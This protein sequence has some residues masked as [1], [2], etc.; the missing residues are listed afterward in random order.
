MVFQRFFG[1]FPPLTFPATQPAHAPIEHIREGLRELLHDCD[2]MA[3]E[4]AIYKI[5]VARTAADL[6]LLRS[7]L[8][9]CIAQAHSQAEAARRINSVLKLFE[10]WLPASRLTRI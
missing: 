7:D 9:Q 5:H 6:W 3:S 10:G 1:V 4:R 2:D 8:H